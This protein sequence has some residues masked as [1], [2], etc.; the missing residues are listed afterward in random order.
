MS[1]RER[2]REKESEREREREREREHV[3]ER[4][5]EHEHVCLCLC[6]LARVYGGGQATG[7]RACMCA[8]LS[9][10]GIDSVREGEE[11]GGGGE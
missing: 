3:H 4:E 5:R 11:G 2:E 10:S 7:K 1:E 8:E 9:T 6:V